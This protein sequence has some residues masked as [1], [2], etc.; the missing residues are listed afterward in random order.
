MQIRHLESKN[1]ISQCDI[2]IIGCG[3]LGSRVAEAWVR[4]GKSVSALTRSRQ[5]AE[6]MWSRGITPIVGDVTDADSLSNLPS[7]DVTLFAVGW[8]RTSGKSMRE[9]YVDGLHNVLSVLNGRTRRFVYISSTSVYGQQ[10]GELVDESSPCEPVRDNGKTCLDA[11]A[12]VWQHFL[13]NPE[14]AATANVLR[15]AGIYGPHRLLS[16]IDSLAAGKPLSGHPDAWLNLIHVDDAVSAVL[17]CAELGR[18]GQTYLVSDTRPIRRREYYSR[19]ASMVGAPQP[20]Y[21]GASTQADGINKRCVNAKLLSDL[22]VTLQ[23]PTIESGLSN[24]LANH[25][26]T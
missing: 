5:N 22:K 23:F 21:S 20:C 14:V 4:L 24:A 10:A 25:S 18:A 9:V 16:R 19:L 17:A 2:L 15:L 12:V 6:Q 7:C 11:E 26:A 8:D 1:I 13:D 3:Y